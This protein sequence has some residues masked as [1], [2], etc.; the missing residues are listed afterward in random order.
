MIATNVTISYVP[1]V[2]NTWAPLYLWF[3]SLKSSTKA[4]T[5]CVHWQMLEDSISFEAFCG[6]MKQQE[7]KPMSD[8]PNVSSFC[9]Q[10][11]VDAVLIACQNRDGQVMF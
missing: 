10:P 1:S 3:P 9:S 7:K 6:V 2:K 5:D 4:L 8:N 11:L